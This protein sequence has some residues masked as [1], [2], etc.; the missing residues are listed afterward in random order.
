M[1]MFPYYQPCC[2]NMMRQLEESSYVRVLHS[3]PG[4]PRVDVYANGNLIARNLRYGSFT[5]YLKLIPGRYKITVYPAGTSSTPIINTTVNLEPNNIYTAAAIG[6]PENIELFTIPDKRVAINPA[7]TNL[8]FIHLSPDAPA[9][10]ITLPDGK[11]LFSNVSYKGITDYI[12]VAPGRYTIQA[13]PAGTD[14]IVLNVPNIVLRGGLNISVY[15][16]GLAKG[17]PGL[18]VLVPLDGSTYL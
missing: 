9:V 16:V 14:K 6:R 13:R 1:Y 5:P 4:A 2:F 8:R 11:V 10:D 15:A 7:M 12:P 3:S 18:Q 17:K